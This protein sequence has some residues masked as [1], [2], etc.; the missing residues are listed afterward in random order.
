MEQG[1]AHRGPRSAD[2]VDRLIEQLGEC[3]QEHLGR[4]IAALD[5]KESCGLIDQLER[6]DL[7]RVRSLY[8]SSQEPAADSGGVN[9]LSGPNAVRLGE[10]AASS[11]VSAAVRR[12]EESLAAG[13]VAIVL[14][15]GGQA[16]RLGCD[17]PK[18]LQPVGPV[19]GASLLQLFCE[20]TAARGELAGRPIPLLIMTSDATD[21]ETRAYLQQHERFGLAEEDVLVFRQGTMPC[22]DATT[23]RLVL[24]SPNSIHVSPDGHG[25]LAPRHA[26][27]RRVRPS[28]RAGRKESLLCTNRQPA[29]VARGPRV[30]W[31]ALRPPIGNDD[32]R[33]RQVTAGRT[34][35]RARPNRR[36][37]AVN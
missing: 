32:A 30:H 22:V 6:L 2:H 23:G 9:S 8:E 21:E 29:H 12:G 28:R 4:R 11:A 26:A 36:R 18:G 35:R 37:H 1:A 24:A 27:S 17:G 15:A 5:A 14:V 16:T 25:G 3:G 31:L 10:R 13:E 33:R 34:R 20:Q 7:P 19:S